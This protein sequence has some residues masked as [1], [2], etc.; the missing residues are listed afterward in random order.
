MK[1]HYCIILTFISMAQHRLDPLEYHK[2]F[3]DSTT[4]IMT[5]AFFILRGKKRG[6][7]LFQPGVSK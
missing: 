5:E 4:K 6:V 2:G 1:V 7:E 3:P